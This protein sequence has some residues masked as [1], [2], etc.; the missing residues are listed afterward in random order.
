[1]ICEGEFNRLSLEARGF[2]AVC[3]TEGA[4]VFLPEWAEHFA[5]IRH[6]FICFNRSV[7]SDRA[8]KRVQQLLPS[9]R[10]AHLPA[11]LGDG[12]T[13]EDFFM[14]RTQLDFEVVLSGALALHT[15]D[16]APGIRELQPVD[17]AA[18][19]ERFRRFDSLHHRVIQ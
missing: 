11:D 1:M 8:A 5:G 4:S 3:S 10:I 14:G 6:V 13:V 19:V 18:D 12:G 16:D 17:R 15:V 7:A 2:P 9:A